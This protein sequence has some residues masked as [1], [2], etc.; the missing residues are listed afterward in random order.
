V[1]Y[2]AT[3]LRVEYSKQDTNMNVDGKPGSFVPEDRSD[4]FCQNG[5]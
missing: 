3:I 1:E 5:S 4:M 2:T